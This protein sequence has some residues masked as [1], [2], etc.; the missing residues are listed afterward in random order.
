[1]PNRVSCPFMSFLQLDRWLYSH[2]VE[3]R[4]RITNACGPV[5]G[6]SILDV[7]CGEMLTDFALVAAGANVTGLDL[8]SESPDKLHAPYVRLADGGFDPP[9]DYAK[10]L[11]YVSY[12]GKNFPFS[13]S[14]YDIV[15]SIGAFE[16]IADPLAVLLEMKR[17]CRP[18]GILYIH[19]YPWWHCF[20]GSHLTDY[21]KEPFFHLNHDSAWV[22]TQLDAH[23]AENP[24]DAGIVNH[25]YG[26][27][28]TLN[29][30]SQRMFSEAINEAGLKISLCDLIC[31]RQKLEGLP[32]GISEV[33]A[34]ICGSEMVLHASRPRR[35]DSA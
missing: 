14:L 11:S 6:K 21:I 28:L 2:Y 22:R 8:A 31:Y 23:L 32:D 20:Y 30:Y 9:R 13:D 24:Q 4:Q 34:M 19:T 10:R 3:V 27:F 33:D 1:M 12:D 15:V 18:G 25:I 29:H 7:G 17:V 35:G 26:E 5:A 16:H